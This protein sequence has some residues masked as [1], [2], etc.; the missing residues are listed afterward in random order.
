[1]IF[2]HCIQIITELK[3]TEDDIY[4]KFNVPS[5]IKKWLSEQ[6]IS[7]KLPDDITLVSTFNRNRGLYFFNK[8]DA[9]LFKM[10]FSGE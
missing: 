1:M 9:V 6:K 2:V 10:T 4:V 7:Y 8:E 5:P 3:T